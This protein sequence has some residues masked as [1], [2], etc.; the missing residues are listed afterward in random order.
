MNDPRRETRPLVEVREAHKTWRTGLRGRRVA[1]D[2]IDLTMTRGRHL[3]LIGSSG[4]GKSTLVRALLGVTRLDSGRIEVLGHQIDGRRPALAHLLQPVAQHAS[5]SLDPRFTVARSIAEPIRCLRLDD[6]IEER[7]AELLD[8]VGLP[9]DVLRR[10]PAE[11][12]GG[13]RQRVAIARA[14]AARPR[15]LLGDEMLSA[16]DAASRVDLIETLGRVA[17]AEDV[18]ILLVAHDLGAARLLCHEVAVMSEGRIV[19][20]GPSDR[21]WAAPRHPVTAALVDAAEITRS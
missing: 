17:L 21:I 8:L 5:G 15:V 16:L 18:T 19:E 11:L 6:P 9:A 7:T 1:L 12:S 2:G 10:R 4:A 13:Q 14:L 3:A 20:Q